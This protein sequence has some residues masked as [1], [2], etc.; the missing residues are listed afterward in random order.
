MKTQT[1]IFILVGVIAVIC[2]IW[3]ILAKRNK[4]PH[5]E[6][7]RPLNEK[8][9]E[10]EIQNDKLVILNNITILEIEKI[11]TD[12]CNLY[13]QE[14]YQAL[15]RLYQLS[16]RQFAVTF[17]YDIEF[18][19]FCFFVNYAHYPMEFKKSFEVTGWTTET[20]TNKKVMLYIP[21]DDTEYDNVYLTTDD[22]IGYKIGFA[23]GNKKQLLDIPKQYFTKPIIEIEELTNK[24]YKDYN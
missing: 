8:L 11:L 9:P 20:S 12:F 7:I 6:N 19:I 22:N 14:K 17:P 21:N 16:E 2:F 15:P 18:K 13:N 3:I 4:A 5:S 23:L 24:D 1:T 10:Q